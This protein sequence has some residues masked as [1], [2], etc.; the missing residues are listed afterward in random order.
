[1]EGYKGNQKGQQEERRQSTVSPTHEDDDDVSISSSGCRI[2]GSFLCGCT[3]LGAK[4]LMLPSS[5]QCWWW[6]EEE[7]EEL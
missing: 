7:K 3:Q 6:M 2:S 1:M 4:M 5:A